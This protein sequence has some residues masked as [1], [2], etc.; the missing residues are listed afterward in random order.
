MVGAA[1]VLPDLGIDLSQI[2]YDIGNLNDDGS[3]IKP[4]DRYRVMSERLFKAAADPSIATIIVDSMTN[5]VEYMQDD[6]RRQ[7][8]IPESKRSQYKFEFD[9]WRLLQHYCK[10]LVT[11]LRNTGKLVIFTAHQQV[12]KDDLDGA[13]KTF[14]AIPGG[15]RHTFAG[16]FSDVWNPQTEKSGFGDKAKAK[17]TINT[18]PDNA[19]D[20]RG[21]KSS[22]KTPVSFPVEDLPKYLPKINHEATTNVSS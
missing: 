2:K 10:N 5:V 19:R 7:R 3:V 1:R 22:M 21:L 8:N 18:L 4:Y 13:F 16:L 15:T 14:L 11:E 12:D 20:Q 17:R 6:I 9:D